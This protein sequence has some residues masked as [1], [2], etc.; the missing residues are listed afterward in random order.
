MGSGR[1]RLFLISALCLS[2][3]CACGRLSPRASELAD[4]AS[5]YMNIAV[6]ADRDLRTDEYYIPQTGRY[7]VYLSDIEGIEEISPDVSVAMQDY[8]FIQIDEYCVW[9]FNDE[10]R[11]EGILCILDSGRSRDLFRDLEMD[12]ER[13]AEDCYLLTQP[14][15]WIG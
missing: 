7:F 1:I 12:R 10:T 9:F 15:A 8:S 14:R 4:N 5:S 13:L 11:T 2:L 3:L 6:F